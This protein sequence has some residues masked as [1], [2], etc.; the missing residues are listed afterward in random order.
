MHRVCADLAGCYENPV[1]CLVWLRSCLSL[2]QILRV[3]ADRRVRPRDSIRFCRCPCCAC[4][5]IYTR[6]PH[7]T[8]RCD[9]RLMALLCFEPSQRRV[10]CN[11]TIT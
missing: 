8:W 1:L 5:V 10:G 2:K 4:R 7:S 11:R 3:G 6:A 9:V